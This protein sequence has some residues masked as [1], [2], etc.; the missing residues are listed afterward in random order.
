MGI[1]SADDK[2]VFQV[3]QTCRKVIVLPLYSLLTFRSYRYIIFHYCMLQ[4]SK[5]DTGIAVICT[6][7]NA[8]FGEFI[9]VVV[10]VGKT[11][12]GMIFR[13]KVYHSMCPVNYFYIYHRLSFLSAF[14]QKY[15][16][17]KQYPFRIHPYEMTGFRFFPIQIRVFQA[18][19]MRVYFQAPFLR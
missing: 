8:V 14:L 10:F 4:N 7:K 13:R 11:H 18:A 5:P 15:R 9:I 3:E 17:Q 16:P 2:A 19:C 1:R 6:D 12:F